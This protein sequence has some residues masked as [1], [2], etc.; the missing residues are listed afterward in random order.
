MNYHEEDPLIEVRRIRAELFKEYGGIDGW[1]KHN[2]EV[3]A[4]REKEGW[5]YATPE[6]LAALKNRH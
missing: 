2:I 4:R 5:R 1:H 6:E 3:R